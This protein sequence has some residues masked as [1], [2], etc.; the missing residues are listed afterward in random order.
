MNRSSRVDCKIRVADESLLPRI[1][2]L[3]ADAVTL[4]WPLA[5]YR[6]A[7]LSGNE[8]WVLQA[9]SGELVGCVVARCC[10]DEGEILNCF[11][12]QQWQGQGWA[13]YLLSWLMKRWQGQNVARCFLEVRVSNEPAQ[14]LYRRVGFEPAG[15]R[16]GYYP[17]QDP[18]GTDREDALVMVCER[19]GG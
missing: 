15:V 4:P 11:I 14:A 6:S 8:V 18:L 2:Q 3:E 7:L 1:A 19:L 13:T 5:H 17:S 9:S 16:R 10:A 12:G